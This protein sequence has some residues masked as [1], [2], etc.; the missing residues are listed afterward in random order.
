MASRSARGPTPFLKTRVFHGRSADLIARILD[1]I[2]ENGVV[3][4]KEILLRESDK[5]IIL[6]DIKTKT[7]IQTNKL[8]RFYELDQAKT[9]VRIIG[10]PLLKDHNYIVRNLVV[11]F[12]QRLVQP[13]ITLNRS[14]TEERK[15][16]AAAQI[17]PTLE[18]IKAGEMILREGERVTEAQLRKLTT[19]N[20]Q[21]HNERVL[22]TAIGASITIICLLL[23]GFVIHVHRPG[24]RALS[25]NKNLLFIAAA[26]VTF[27][28]LAK[29]SWSLCE[30]LAR[31]GP[32]PITPFSMTFGI[33]LAA[34][35]HG[36]LPVFRSRGGRFLCSRPCR[37]RGIFISKPIRHV[38]LFFSQQHHG[39]LLGAGL[40]GEEGVCHRRVEG[41][42]AQ[43]GAGNCHGH[44]RRPGRRVQ[45]LVGLAVCGPWAVSGRASSPPGWH[46]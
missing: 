2:M 6:Q 38:Y 26:L 27:L 18:K 1:S 12:T 5:G 29:V 17:A 24:R 36:G 35:G 14:E 21:T 43:R 15:R 10:Q 4:N 9:M 23:S 45:A 32:L 13:N 19:L 39:R 20:E 33:P 22:T 3:T 8:R 42:A 41:R 11:D 30:M 46:R 25:N 28:F 16:A 31:S 44:L 34:G 37:L 40:P 7:E